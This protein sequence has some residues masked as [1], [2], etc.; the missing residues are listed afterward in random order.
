MKNYNKIGIM[1]GRL[2]KPIKNKIQSFPVN[3]WKTEFETASTTGFE[4]LEWVFDEIEP[5]P[6]LNDD[7][8]KE[9]K[10]FSEKFQI[11]INS[12]CADYFM[13]NK[14]FNVSE[15]DLR[16]N[17]QILK[18]LI[19][20]CNSLEIEILEIPF[21]DISSMKNQ[22]DKI[23][24]LKN[25]KDVLLFA[26]ENNVKITLETD[27]PATEFNEFLLMFDLPIFANYDIGNSTSLGF[28]VVNEL[29]ILS[30]WIRN[31]HIK[32]RKLHGSTV[33]LGT[34]DV[35][36]DEFF[37]NVA[38]IKYKYDFIIQGAREDLADPHIEPRMTCARYLKFTNDYIKKYF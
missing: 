8:I 10:Y 11:K 26:K 13:I 25:L 3:S 15:F 1:S 21:V 6:I 4:L 38:K 28:D 33:S 5:N 17:I 34:G 27:L 18:E 23:Q 37:S 35:D 12:V 36:F 29:E 30:E 20:K 24:V 9:I 16:K 22:Q 2:S 7:G 31:I 32:D 19:S 14:I